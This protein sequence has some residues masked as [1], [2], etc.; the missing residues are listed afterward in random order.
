MGVPSSEVG[1]TPTMPRGGGPRSPQKDMW[2]HW[3]RK[4]KKSLLRFVF[5]AAVCKQLLQK[6]VT[7]TKQISAAI[8]NKRVC[9]CIKGLG[10]RNATF[11]DVT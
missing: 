3:K 4:K 9:L 11:F 8:V 2:W 5:K 1:Y 6:F 7:G 10:Q